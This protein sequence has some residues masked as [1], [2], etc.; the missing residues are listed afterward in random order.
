MV[1]TV[2]DIG[3]PQ[4]PQGPPGPDSPA[5]QYGGIYRDVLSGGQALLAGVYQKLTLINVASAPSS[6]VTTTPASA[7]ITI[8]TPG[9]HKIYF[10]TS[11]RYTLAAIISMSLHVNSVRVPAITTSCLGTPFFP[12]NVESAG[13]VSLAAADVV[14]VFV[15]PSVAASMS[16]E[17]AQLYVERADP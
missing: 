4:G 7:S 11:W 3:G 16:I 6:G 15:N 13:F 2:P 10:Q 9:V 8:I 5:L 1:F 12:T 14:E 17:R